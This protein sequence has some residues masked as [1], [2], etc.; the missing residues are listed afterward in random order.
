M[1]SG[2]SLYQRIVNFS[3]DS[4]DMITQVTIILGTAAPRVQVPFQFSGKTLRAVSLHSQYH[5]F[6]SGTGQRVEFAQPLVVLI[7]IVRLQDV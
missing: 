4:P 6:P 5:P 2:G 3:S 1:K 7:S